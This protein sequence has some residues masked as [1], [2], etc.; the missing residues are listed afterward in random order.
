MSRR[1]LVVD[2]EQ[3]IRAA[4]GQL[5]EYEGYEVR[6]ESQRAGRHRRVREMAAAPRLPR[7]EDGGHGRPRGAQAHPA[8]RSDRDRRDDQRPRDDPDRG[9]GHAARRV[10]HPREA[11]RHRPH[12]RHCC[13]TRCSTSS[14]Q[15]E[16]ARLTRDDRVALRDRRQ[17][18][19]DSRADRTRSRRSRRRRRACSSPARTAPARSSSRARSID[20]RRAPNKPF[21]EVN[22][23]AIPSELI[24]SELFGHMKGSFTGADRATARASSSR[25]TAARSSSTRSAT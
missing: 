12:S 14:L 15:E 23:A 17:V 1:I 25:P 10:R 6:A 9:R 18:V 8:D 19:R 20:S 13:A 7:R 16:N 3:G 21:V 2:D 5:L 11:A 24:E 4:L 22:C